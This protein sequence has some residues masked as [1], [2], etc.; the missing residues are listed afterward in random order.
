MFAASVSLTDGVLAIRG[1]SGADHVEIATSMTMR[2]SANRIIT[3]DTAVLLNGNVHRFDSSAIK[4]IVVKL[5]AGNDTFDLRQGE[6]ARY[7]TTNGKHVPTRCDWTLKAEGGDGDDVLIGSRGNE[8][9]MG[10]K[11]DDSLNGSW[12]NDATYGDAGND[13][14]TEDSGRDRIDGG[15][16]NDDIVLM[17]DSSVGQPTKIYGGSGRDRV[18]NVSSSGRAWMSSIAVQ[19]VAKNHEGLKHAWPLGWQPA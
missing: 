11:G 16:G 15:S 2:K 10:G 1:S 8:T 17:G 4:A 9:L 19:L 12:G 7:V 14:L 18:F 3:N 13:V 5:G 6:L